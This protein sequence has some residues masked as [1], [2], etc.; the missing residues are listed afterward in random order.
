MVASSS[1]LLGALASGSG[2]SSAS[3]IGTSSAA[4]GR[5]TG[6]LLPLKGV[7]VADEVGEGLLLFFYACSHIYF[8]FFIFINI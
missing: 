4:S 6:T 2:A 5:S 3:A 7:V 8:G 1:K